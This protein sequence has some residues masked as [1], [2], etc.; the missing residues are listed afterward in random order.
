MLVN[1]GFLKTVSTQ[2][3]RPWWP[4]QALPIVRTECWNADFEICIT[5]VQ[6]T[7][8]WIF[9][10]IRRLTNHLHYFVYHCKSKQFNLFVWIFFKIIGG[11]EIRVALTKFVGGSVTTFS[12]VIIPSRIW[13]FC[14][15]DRNYSGALK[16]LQL[17]L[18]NLSVQLDSDWNG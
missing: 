18:C 7:N 11:Y 1:S 9:M 14:D 15:Q 5:L 2:D 6:I 10:L 4:K 13:D 16:K 12:S 17:I 3:R 8:A